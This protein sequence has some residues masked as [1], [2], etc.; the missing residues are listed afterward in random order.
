MEIAALEWFRIESGSV[1]VLFLGLDACLQ[2]RLGPKHRL[3]VTAEVVGLHVDLIV[4]PLEFDE[5]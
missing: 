1:V 5:R 3:A 2:D 4:V